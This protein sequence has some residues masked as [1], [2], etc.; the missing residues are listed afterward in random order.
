MAAATRAVS[1]A[2]GGGRDAAP[3]SSRIPPPPRPRSDPVQEKLEEFKA[4]NSLLGRV[5][6][7]LQAEL[8]EKGRQLAAAKGKDGHAGS[9]IALLQRKAEAAEAEA[10]E[11]EERLSKQARAHARR[12]QELEDALL[13]V[14]DEA[15]HL[16]SRVQQL[17][18]ERGSLQ[19]HMARAERSLRVADGAKAEA[20][21]AVSQAEEME[22]SLRGKVEQME[23]SLQRLAQEG[24]RKAQ[25]FSSALE[26]LEA[27][28]REAQSGWR[29]DASC[30]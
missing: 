21:R 30:A 8:E 28:W 24:E 10:A 6:K 15:D 1:D 13:D 3:R 2:P 4:E 18:Q 19:A 20:G 23:R 27:A 14:K 12:V 17:E 22:R 9:K 11:R 7:D 26:G 16:R 5:I 25:G 29:A